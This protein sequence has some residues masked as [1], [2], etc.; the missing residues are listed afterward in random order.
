MFISHSIH[1]VLTLPMIMWHAIEYIGL[2][3]F[4]DS[5]GTVLP[6]GL[7]L[8]AFQN[9]SIL[10]DSSSHVE[11]FN[12][13]ASEYSAFGENNVN[14]FMKQKHPILMSQAYYNYTIKRLQMFKKGTQ[15]EGAGKVLVKD[16]D[17]DTLN[18]RIEA[19][20]CHAEKYNIVN[21]LGK[22][23]LCPS[24]TRFLSQ[25]SFFHCTSSANDDQDGINPSIYTLRCLLGT[26]HTY[27]FLC[28]NLSHC[29][30]I[31]CKVRYDFL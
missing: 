11:Q 24:W 6:T 7:T 18:K 17:R 8:K 3:Q 5:N 30:G 26:P 28:C 27:G 13:V 23:L 16:P 22:K 19:Y 31:P 20:T 12:N 29:D 1:F 4:Y 25:R 9:R 10:H 15:R 21:V 2:Q 14:G